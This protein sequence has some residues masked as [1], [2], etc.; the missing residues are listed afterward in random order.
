M[1]SQEVPMK[2]KDA[3]NL[4]NTTRRGPRDP[5]LVEVMRC[6]ACRHEFAVP[7]QVAG[8]IEQ[9]KGKLPTLCRPCA[10]DKRRASR[11]VGG[12]KP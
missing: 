7:A 6:D 4:I 5:P 8:R 3:A 9:A 12:K 1:V 10:L 2:L 11:R